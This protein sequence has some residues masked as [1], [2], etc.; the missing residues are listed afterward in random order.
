MTESYNV[1]PHKRP[2]MNGREVPFNPIT[3]EGIAFPTGGK[4]MPEYDIESTAESLPPA[5]GKPNP[6][7]SL[8]VDP[9]IPNYPSSAIVDGDKYLGPTQKREQW[10]DGL[11]D[12]VGKHYDSEFGQWLHN[13]QGLDHMTERTDSGLENALEMV[14]SKFTAW[15]NADDIAREAYEG[16]ILGASFE[17]A[18][19]AAPYARI[20]RKYS[21]LLQASDW[22]SDTVNDQILP[23]RIGRQ[24]RFTPWGQYK[25]DLAIVDKKRRAKSDELKKKKMAEYEVMQQKIEDNKG[26]QM[27]EHDWDDTL[28]FSP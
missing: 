18:A 9:S 6:N 14:P 26:F 21:G 19:A 24:E 25:S 28:P 8:F 27:P 3:G 4:P 22:A 13:G 2:K 15:M 11:W 16:D 10:D 7:E 12:A 17:T 20:P 5:P 1:E 23:E